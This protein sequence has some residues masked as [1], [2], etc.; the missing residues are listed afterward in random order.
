MDPVLFHLIVAPIV[1]YGVCFL[2]FFELK[3][4][5]PRARRAPLFATVMSIPLSYAGA[6]IAVV[7]VTSPGP[8]YAPTWFLPLIICAGLAAQ[9][10][11][12]W[13]SYTSFERV[14]GPDF[15]MGSAPLGEGDGRSTPKWVLVLLT[16]WGL[17]LA[18][19]FAWT[20]LR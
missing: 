12:L 19:G 10:A 17:A 1:L 15:V 13:Y 8:H 18:A 5:L 11:G 3:N 7:A 2:G 16:V 4:R 14:Y 6:A 20:A 9:F